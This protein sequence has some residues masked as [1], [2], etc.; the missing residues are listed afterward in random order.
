M[1]CPFDARHPD[2]R[3]FRGRPLGP[4]APFSARYCVSI[5]HRVRC[6]EWLLVCGPSRLCAPLLWPLLTSARPSSASYDAT[7]SKHASR[8]PRVRRVTVTPSTRRIYAAPVR[9][10][11]G[12]ESFCPLAHQ[13]C[14]SSAVRAP[15]ARVMP[16]ASFPPHLAMTPLL[17][18]S[19]FLSSRPPED[20][21]LHVISR[22]AFA[23]G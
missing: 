21:H 14:A 16:A 7:S 20:L 10:T 15:R 4:S 19:G 9:M 2:L 8:S 3:P 13:C 1:P 6:H 17:F 22:L 12:F 11:S 23:I 18:G 5:G